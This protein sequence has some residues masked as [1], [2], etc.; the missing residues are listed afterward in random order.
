MKL[1]RSQFCK[2]GPGTCVA[3]LHYE[4]DFKLIFNTRKEGVDIMEM[5][6]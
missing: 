4:Q 5:K 2:D 6:R 3:A 1:I